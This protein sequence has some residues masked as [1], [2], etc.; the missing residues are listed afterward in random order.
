MLHLPYANTQGRINLLRGPGAQM[1]Y[2]AS[3][4]DLHPHLKALIMSADILL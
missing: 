4:D 3:T 1:D 2:H